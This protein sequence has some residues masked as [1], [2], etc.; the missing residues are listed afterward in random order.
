VLAARVADA[1]PAAERL[2]TAAALVRST[3]SFL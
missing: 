3:P 2:R 1:E